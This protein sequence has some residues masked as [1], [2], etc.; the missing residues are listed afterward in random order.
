MRQPSDWDGPDRVQA[1][2]TWP[3]DDGSRPKAHGGLPLPVHRGME[4]EDWL[5]ILGAASV[6]IITQDFSMTLARRR[7]AEHQLIKEHRCHVF[8]IKMRGNHTMWDILRAVVIAWARWATTCNLW[9]LVS[10]AWWIS[11]AGQI[12]S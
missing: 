8:A 10:W 9:A 7:P 3:G 5:P 6:P 4:D 1:G 2:V 12:E 11:R